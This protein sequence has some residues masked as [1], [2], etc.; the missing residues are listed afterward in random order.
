MQTGGG[1]P[2]EAGRNTVGGKEDEKEGK[3]VKQLMGR[4]EIHKRDG[5]R[6]RSLRQDCGVRGGGGR[7]WVTTLLKIFHN[8]GWAVEN[9]YWEI[10]L[11]SDGGRQNVKKRQGNP[12]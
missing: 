9:V 11:A 1:A 3:R 6:S 4:L 7:K 12:G 5:I 2:G 10:F 8:N